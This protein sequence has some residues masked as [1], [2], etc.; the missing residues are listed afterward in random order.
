MQA[1]KPHLNPRSEKQNKILH[2]RRGFIIIIGL[3]IVA[4]TMYYSI[5]VQKQMV[6]TV[7]EIKRSN[8][9][10]QAKSTA[11]SIGDFVNY[12]VNKHGAGFSLDPTPPVNCEY[13]GGALV[14]VNPNSLCMEGS[15]FYEVAQRQ[16]AKG[17]NMT[18]KVVVKGKLKDQANNKYGTCVGGL[19]DCYGV[20]AP[21]TG[22][23]GNSTICQAYRDSIENSKDAPVGPTS[24]TDPN[25]NQNDGIDNPCNWN[26]LSFGSSLT[27]RVAIPLYSDNSTYFT[28]SLAGLG[29][30]TANMPVLSNPFSGD[31]ASANFILRVRTPC[32]P[33]VGKDP[34]TTKELPVTPGYR[35]CE[36][37]I[38]GAN[39]ANTT[40]SPYYCADSER[41]VL[42]TTEKDG[43]PDDT[44]V[45]WQITGQCG[46]EECGMIPFK[47]PDS[48][49]NSSSA[50][51]SAIIESF[52]NGD[53]DHTKKI[54]IDTSATKE[55]LIPKA[56]DTS[57]Y[58]G[59]APFILDKLKLMTK[60]VFSMFLSGKLISD[61][62]QFV[63]YLEYQFLSDT[64]VGQ[65]KI[66]SEI[67][68]IIN[69]VVYTQN[70]EKAEKRPLVDFAIQ[71]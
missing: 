4:L 19:K 47:G 15:Y 42:N 48:T 2:N 39:T 46:E 54:I 6:N 14:T 5:M 32:L 70:I 45:S 55:K 57:D 13:K 24:S 56:K 37:T 25:Q 59:P 3:S 12:V 58:A 8:D 69:D 17:N 35:S 44:V 30:L 23:A 68:V 20:P 64:P 27:D 41:Y 49:Y 51:F 10:F 40:K 52:I 43:T 16:W 67:Q 29:S 31:N 63:P 71:N 33:C 1:K 50:G 60:P 28:S 9:L 62:G 65:A 22:D 66:E 21:A 53:I 38:T 11:Q 34:K 18:I 7:Y 36:G 26:K 61:S